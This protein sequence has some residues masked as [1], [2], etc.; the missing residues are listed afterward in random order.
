MECI[1]IFIKMQIFYEK[2]FNDMLLF[3]YFVLDSIFTYKLK[4]FL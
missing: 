2:L 4:N 1:Y 3:I